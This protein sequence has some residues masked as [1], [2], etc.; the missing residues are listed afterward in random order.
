MLRVAR[1]EARQESTLMGGIAKKNKRALEV[2]TELFDIES[3]IKATE[4]KMR[5]P[6]FGRGDA[7]V[8]NILSM[9]DA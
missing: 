6:S 4:N 3:I 5:N 1:D 8:E 2:I 9:V 7:T